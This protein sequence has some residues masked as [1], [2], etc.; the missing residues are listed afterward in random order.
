MSSPDLTAVSARP[1]APDGRVVS[2]R[3]VSPLSSRAWASGHA[4]G[5]LPDA[6]PYGLHRLADHGLVVD[7]RPMRVPVGPLARRLD[8]TLRHRGAGWEWWS[9]RGVTSSDADMVV[10]WDERTGVPAGLGSAAVA[11]GVVWLTDTRPP[12]L[13]VAV[14]RRALRRAA[15]VWVLSDAQLQPVREQWGVPSSRLHRV[16][17]GI[18]EVF[19]SPRGDSTAADGPPVV[20]GVGND[21]HRDHAGLVAAVAGLPARLALVTELPVDVPPEVGERLTVLDH[22]ALRSRYESAAVV[23]VLLRPNLHVSGVTTLLEAQAMGRPVVVSDTPGIREYLEPGVTADLV[24]VGDADAARAAIAGLLADPARAAA[25]GAAGRRLVL[26]RGRSADMVAAL[27]EI[28]R[29][30]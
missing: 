23:A 11:T 1:A 25:M 4:E 18:D 29:A 22:L 2:L 10:S 12:P 17:F 3:V 27:A 26:R 16:P 24:P 13:F 19:W 9:R 8:G 20:L 7:P 28:L 5:R 30:V 14:A 6:S 15:A 21:R